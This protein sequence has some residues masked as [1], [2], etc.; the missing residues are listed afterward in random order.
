M[1]NGLIFPSRCQAVMSDGGTQGGRSGVA[2][3][4]KP[5][6]SPDRQIRSGDDREVMGRRGVRPQ[7]ARIEPELP[8]KAS[9]QDWRRPYRK[10][11]QVGW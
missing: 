7:A 1:D 5:V 2:R 8:R 11:T 10:P 9:S 4:S 3:P 6:G